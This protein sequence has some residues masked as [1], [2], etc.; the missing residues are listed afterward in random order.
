MKTKFLFPAM[1]LLAAAVVFSGCINLSST[2]RRGSASSKA[3]DHG[4]P[5]ETALRDVK[6]VVAA[7]VGK[8]QDD[9]GFQEH[10]A[11]LAEKKGSL[12]VLQIGNIDNMTGERVV[13]K[14]ESARRRLE[15]ALRKTRLFD[16]TDDASSGE[17]VSAVLA[18]SITQNAAIGLNDGANLQH[19]GSHVSAD[20][21]VYGRFRAFEDGK[22][23]VYELSLQLIDLST[24]KQI[25][26]DLEEV[27]K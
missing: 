16:I 5:D 25:W 20:Y 2:L 11:L 27:E 6:T 4:K 15:I 18:D 7:L 23:K 8:M 10:Y 13:Q 17:S 22:S 14:L 19:F 12:P 3:V 24:G 21:Q 1:A 26:S 9:E